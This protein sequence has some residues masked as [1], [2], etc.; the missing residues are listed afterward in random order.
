MKQDMFSVMQRVD[1][2]QQTFFRPDV[3]H[4]IILMGG[5]KLAK[6]QVLELLVVIFNELL[7]F[8]IV[9][10]SMNLMKALQNPKW[11]K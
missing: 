9:H 5:L 6:A 7:L 11:Q 8:H 10:L 3:P 2:A 1:A 4:L